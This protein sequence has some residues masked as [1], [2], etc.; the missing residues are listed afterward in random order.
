MDTEKK[1]SR[2]EF[3]ATIGGIGLAVFLA[4]FS[5]FSSIGRMKS[6]IETRT[7]ASVSGS[8]GNSFYGGKRSV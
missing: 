5:R 6:A 1:L 3:L 4:K 2:R 8:Y 7:T